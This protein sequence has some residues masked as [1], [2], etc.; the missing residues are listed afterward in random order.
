MSKA[1]LRRKNLALQGTQLAQGP[2]LRTV[3]EEEGLEGLISQSSTQRCGLRRPL[4]QFE[5]R[6]GRLQCTD[7]KMK[8]AVATASSVMS[9]L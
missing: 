1:Q 2:D 5:D 8:K 4:L 9:F 3:E 7:W 6:Q